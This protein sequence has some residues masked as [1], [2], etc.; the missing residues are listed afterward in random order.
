VEMSRVWAEM[1][2]GLLVVLLKLLV[3]LGLQMKAMLLLLMAPL[4]ELLRLLVPLPSPRT[5]Q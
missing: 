5:H 4:L 2:G 1:L 3:L